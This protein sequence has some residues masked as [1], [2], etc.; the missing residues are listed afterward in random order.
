MTVK[1]H[2]FRGTNSLERGPPGKTPYLAIESNTVQ[3]FHRRQL[4]SQREENVDEFGNE[5]SERSRQAGSAGQ[6]WAGG[7]IR[8]HVRATSVSSGRRHGHVF[9][10]SWSTALSEICWSQNGPDTWLAGK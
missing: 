6:S 10:T 8:G 2:T 5:I 1:V 9:L 4:A 3:A 7:R